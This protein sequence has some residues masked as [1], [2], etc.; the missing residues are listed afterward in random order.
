MSTVVRHL[1]IDESLNKR[2]K[3][4]LA[5]RGRPASAI[6]ELGLLSTPDD[7]LLHALAERFGNEPWVIVTKDD[8]MPRDHADTIADLGVTVATIDSRF[9]LAKVGIT[10]EEMHRETVHRWV[11][12]MA[13]MGDGELRR[14]H[15]LG[16]RKWTVR[17]S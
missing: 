8:N 1:V 14:F 9:D 11:H 2:L 13:A 4:E 6:S 5:S 17:R 7:L 16:H 15:P 3:S 10:Q 12:L